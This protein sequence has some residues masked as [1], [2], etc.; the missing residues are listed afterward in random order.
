MGSIRVNARALRKDA[1]SRKARL[2]VEHIWEHLRENNFY[3][4]AFSSI[5]QVEDVLCQGL[6]Q[7]KKCLPQ[8]IR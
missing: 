4:Q 5:E 2:P 3:N 6:Y 1:S 7:F 8:M